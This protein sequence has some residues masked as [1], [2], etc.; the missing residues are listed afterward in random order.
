MS[1]LESISVEVLY[2]EH[3]NWLQSWLCRRMGCAY[4]AQDLTQDTF[5]RILKNSGACLLCKTPR[6][7]LLTV[8]KSLMIDKWRREEIE[9]AYL[10]ALAQLPEA[11]SPSS[12][13]LNE[14]IETLQTIDKALAKLPE[15][16]RS[17][18]MMAQFE[19]MKYREIAEVLEVSER[20]VK[21]YMAQAMMAC[22]L[23]S[24]E[25]GASDGF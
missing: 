4:D 12:E 5:V 20:M 24:N 25:D 16:P 8:A 22:I 10:E 7:Y 15:K 19:G 6:A 11:T 23:A 13:A 3:Q 1:E 18:F 9:K 2:K 17:A 14:I 21:K